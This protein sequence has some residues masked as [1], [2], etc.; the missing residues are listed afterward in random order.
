MKKTTKSLIYS[1]WS[2]V[3]IVTIAFV[4]IKYY[5]K[6]KTNT[7]MAVTP[8]N[9]EQQVVKG[10]YTSRSDFGKLL[11]DSLLKNN[12]YAVVT[13]GTSD[14]LLCH[15]LGKVSI[16]K[17][18]NASRVTLDYK[19]S[20]HNLLLSQALFPPGFPTTYIID[21][22]Y[23]IIGAVRGLD[24]FKKNTEAIISKRTKS[25]PLHIAGDVSK[26]NEL[27]VLSDA[28]KSTVAK[29]E[30]NYEKMHAFARKSLSN[31]SYFYNNYLLYDYFTKMGVKDSSSFYKKR[32]LKYTYRINSHIYHSLI[33]ELS[34]SN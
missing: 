29:L 27:L 26:S 16:D 8:K 7:K 21:R 23:N 20:D 30:G 6:Q 1:A 10:W 9:L 12:R 18:L 31:G 33:E 17:K 13:I 11:L 4:G 22:E 32:T 2:I 5:N 3:L 14:C 24:E 28:L 25:T 34:S 19:F 15:E